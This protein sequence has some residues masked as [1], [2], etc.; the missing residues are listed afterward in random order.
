MIGLSTTLKAFN[1]TK[2]ME[3]TRNLLVSLF[4]ILTV[5]IAVGAGT[6]NLALGKP[7]T[8]SSTFLYHSINPVAGYAVDGNT[9]GYFLN[10]S[11]THT[12][13]AQ[14]NKS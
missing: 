13:Y 12:E 11:T 14:L 1:E 5:V 8:Q 2:M 6:I 10:K 4:F 9:D 3:T 7:A